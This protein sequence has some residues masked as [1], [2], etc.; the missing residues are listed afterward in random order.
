M[1]HEITVD[2]PLAWGLHTAIDLYD[3]DLAVMTDP[4]ALRRFAADLVDLLD[5]EAYGPPI[6]E[7]FGCGT[8]KPGDPEH[9]KPDTA[10]YTLVQLIQTSSITGHFAD[11][12]RRIFLD[13][14]SCKAY[15]PAV[16]VEFSRTFFHAGETAHKVLNRGSLRPARAAVDAVPG[17]HG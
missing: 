12:L 2:G 17:P 10:G 13:V 16:V 7:F 11:G 14:F 1:T 3:C 5:M 8:W 4:D 6:V 15:D 9:E